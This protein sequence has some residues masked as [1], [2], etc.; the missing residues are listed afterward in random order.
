VRVTVRM[1]DPFG[2][3][4]PRMVM[5]SMVGH[6]LLLL[7]AIFLPGLL[8][9]ATPPRWDPVMIGSLVELPAGGSPPPPAA[10]ASPA[11]TQPTPAPREATPPPP[12]PKPKPKPK[13][14]PA[15][16]PVATKA[17]TPAPTPQAAS[18]EPLPATTAAETGSGAGVSGS[19]ATATGAGDAGTGIGLSAGGGSFPHAYYLSLIKNKLQANYSVPVHPGGEI[20][21]LAVR[22]TFRLGRN[23]T[24]SQVAVEI[25]SPYPPL[26]DAALRAVYS[27][28]PFPSLPPA[29]TADTLDMAVTFDL[30]PLGL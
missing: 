23:G 17:P 24:L 29:Y 4:I 26:D 8:P 5:A 20:G 7:A 19:P 16:K 1:P 6:V 22:I 10:A 25:P 28:S 14:A 15:K 3:G 12:P 13:P 18:P 21:V 9:R 30:K 2:P 11:P 27:S